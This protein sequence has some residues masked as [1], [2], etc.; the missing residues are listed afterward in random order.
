V[1]KALRALPNDC[2]ALARCRW[3]KPFLSDAVW[4]DGFGADPQILGKVIKL[5]GNLYTVIGVMPRGFQFPFNPQKPQI[6][7]PIE[8]GESDKIRIKNATR[9]YG[10]IARLKSQSYRLRWRN[11]IR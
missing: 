5:N 3:R 1:E 2:I 8:L 7:T 4:R 6:W 11:N 10:I 9:E